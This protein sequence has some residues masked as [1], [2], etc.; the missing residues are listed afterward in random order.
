MS[1][2]D[3][4]L[5]ADDLIVA[6]DSA[7]KLQT[8]YLVWQKALESKDLKVNANKT[9]TIVCSNDDESVVIFDNKGNTLKQA[10]TFKYLGSMINARGGCE[11][12]VRQNKWKE[13]SG[14]ICDRRMSVS[15]K[16]KVYRTMIY[17]AKAW[18]LRKSEEQLLE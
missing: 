12:N 3:E 5:C 6:Q 4:M 8:R 17:G 16:V 9:E 14:V 2:S 10:E 13:L 1:L 15:I 18:T 7:H 11:E